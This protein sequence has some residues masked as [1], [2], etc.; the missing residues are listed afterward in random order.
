M[1]DILFK[2]KNAWLIIFLYI[3]RIICSHD[4][5]VANG[6]FKYCTSE[7]VFEVGKEKPG[8]ECSSVVSA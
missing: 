4:I 7:N 8:L 5:V 1:T 3:C 2:I 6:N